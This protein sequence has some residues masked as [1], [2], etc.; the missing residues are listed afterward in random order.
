MMHHIKHH[1]KR[2]HR[3]VV[4]YKHHYLLSSLVVAAGFLTHFALTD[5]TPVGAAGT[6]EL[7]VDMSSEIEIGNGGSGSPLV[8]IKMTSPD[9]DSL[10][11]LNFVMN[12]AGETP[13]NFTKDDIYVV[14]VFVDNGN[15]QW[16]G[17]GVD[18]PVGLAMGISGVGEENALNMCAPKFDEQGSL[19]GCDPS[20][21]ALPSSVA[22]DFNLMFVAFES[23]MKEGDAF[24]LSLTGYTLSS[25]EEV[26]ISGHKTPV[27]V[28]V[29]NE[30]NNGGGGGGLVNMVEINDFQNSFVTFGVGLNGALENG[31]ALSFFFNDVQQ[32]KV[33]FPNNNNL[34]LASHNFE[35][36]SDWDVVHDESQNV[37][38]LVYSDTGGFNGGMITVD[39]LEGW[40]ISNVTEMSL[41]VMVSS[42]PNDVHG[43]VVHSQESSSTICMDCAEEGGGEGSSFSLSATSILDG[44][45]DVAVDSPV[46]AVFTE[47]I[48]ASS[49]DSLKVTLVESGVGINLCD[50]L[51]YPA[52]PDTSAISCAYS[53][54]L[55][56]GTVYEFYV[57]GG[58]DG[59]ASTGVNTLESDVFVTFTT[60]SKEG[61]EKEIGGGELF[62]GYSSPEANAGDVALSD[63]ITVGVLAEIDQT[64]VNS[65]TVLLQKDGTGD[66]LCESYGFLSTSE[67]ECFYSGELSASSLY[68]LTIV[69]GESGVKGLSGETFTSNQEIPFVTGNGLVAPKV[70]GFWAEGSD[71]STTTLVGAM[72]ST[73]MDTNTITTSSLALV[74]FDEGGMPIPVSL[75]T[76]HTFENADTEIYCT[77]DGA[78]KDATDYMFIASTDITD[79]NGVNL[80]MESIGYFTTVGES[81]GEGKK[82]IEEPP[83]IDD[84]SSILSVDPSDGAEGVFVSKRVF[85]VVYDGAI[86]DSSISPLEDGLFA[87]DGQGGSVVG[88]N[89]CTSLGAGVD[90][91][92]LECTIPDEL[93]T[94]TYY[95]FVATVLSNDGS[96]VLDT[97]SE[98]RTNVTDSGVTDPPRVVSVDPRSG[99]RGFPTDGRIAVGFSRDMLNSIGKA[100]SITEHE[101]YTLQEVNVNGQ[102]TGEDVCQDGC[103]F[104]VDSDDGGR[105]VVFI[106][107]NS[108]LL[109]NTE[110]MLT[111]EDTIEDGANISL[112]SAVIVFFETG[113]QTHVE[114]FGELGFSM[115]PASGTE[116]PITQS[117]IE[118]WPS[119]PRL[120]ADSV[121]TTTVVLFADA[122]E[123]GMYDL[124]ETKATD[125]GN[126]LIEYLQNKNVV[127]ANVPGLLPANAQLCAW[128]PP[129]GVT[130]S[131]G[132]SVLTD[133]YSCF[134]TE[135]A[136]YTA[137]S[138]E[139]EG[140]EVDQ[141]NARIW[142]SGPLHA[143]SAV[144]SSSYT[145]YSP[146]NSAIP[147][148]FE[149]VSLEYD[150]SEYRVDIIG[151]TFEPGTDVKV[152]VKSQS[153]PN[154]EATM[155]EDESTNVAVATVESGSYLHDEFDFDTQQDKAAWHENPINLRPEN[156]LA[157]ESGGRWILE[158]QT[159]VALPIGSSIR[160]ILPVGFNVTDDT[161]P[162]PTEY[163]HHNKNIRGYGSTPVT[164]DSYTTNSN[165]RSITFV[166][167]GADIAAADQVRLELVGVNNPNNAGVEYAGRIQ[168]FDENGKNVGSYNAKPFTIQT[169][170]ALTLSGSVYADDNGNNAYDAGEEISGARVFCESRSGVPFHKVAQVDPLGQ[171]QITNVGEN[172]R[173]A[174]GLQPDRSAFGNRYPLHDYEEFM[175]DT[176]D[177]PAI[178]FI[179]SSDLTAVGGVDHTFF[180]NGDSSLESTEIDITCFWDNRS[181]VETVTL[182]AEGFADVTMSLPE[183]V[184]VECATRPHLDSTL[185]GTGRESILVESDYMSE[186]ID[187]Y[188]DPN[189]DPGFDSHT[190]SLTTLDQAIPVRVVGSD[191]SAIANAFVGIVPNQCFDSGSSR[192]SGCEPRAYKT[193]GDGTK[194]IPAVGG[195]FEVAA[196]FKGTS[197]S[198][199]TVVSVDKNGQVWDEFGNEITAANPL[200]LVLSVSSLTISGTYTRGDNAVT[201]EHVSLEQIQ[202]GGTCES[203][204]RI[205]NWRH[206]V[207]DGEGDFTA[208]VSD[209]TWIVEARG[210]CE[211]VVVSGSSRSGI[212]LNFDTADETTISGI[213]PAGAVIS[214]Y[215]SN[216]GGYAVAG[217][218]GV[219]TMGILAGSVSEVSCFSHN[220]GPC[221]REGV[222]SNSDQTINFSTS[223]DTGTLVVNAGGVSDLFVDARN[224]FGGNGTDDNDSGVYTLSL[225]AGSYTVRGANPRLGDIC[226]AQTV[227][228]AKDTTTEVTCSTDSLGALVTPAGQ[229]VDQDGTPI[230]GASVAFINKDTG[231]RF[232]TTSDASTSGINY[233]VLDAP[234]G[235]YHIVARLSGYEPGAV[236]VALSADGKFEIDEDIVLTSAS[237][238]N[239]DVV[240]VQVN[241]NG[242]N[243]YTGIARVVAEKQDGSGGRV[244]KEVNK[245]TGQ[246]T[247]S[248]TNGTWNI[249]ARG[250][251]GASLETTRVVT[252]GSL[253]GGDVTLALTQAIS[254]V[255]GPETDTVSISS[256]KEGV[257]FEAT[258]ISLVEKLIIPENTL[259]LSDSGAGLLE[260]RQDPSI[261]LAD[262]GDG[263]EIVGGTGVDIYV[264]DSS[265]NKKGSSLTG[266]PITLTMNYT[267]EDVTAAGVQEDRLQIFSINANGEL[268]TFSTTVDTENNTLTAQVTHFS[269]FG[270]VG[271]TPSSS[272]GGSGDGGGQV[273][274]AGESSGAG[275]AFLGVNPPTLPTPVSKNVAET[276]VLEVEEESSEV[277]SLGGAEHTLTVLLQN[278]DKVA[279]TIE[280]NPVSLTLAMGE[281][282]IIDTD[283]DEILDLYV[284][285]LTGTVDG[286]H[287]FK[288]R[289]LSDEAERTT[290]F[291]INAGRY[292]V[293]DR[294]VLLSFNVP[295][296]VEVLVSEEA[297]FADAL[298]YTPYTESRMF[299]LSSGNGTKSV[300]VRFRSA[301][302]GIV[303][304]VD[305]IMLTGQR[306]NQAPTE[307]VVE[308]PETVVSCVLK[309]L[310]AYMSGDSAAVYYV[311]NACTK[312]PFK[313]AAIFFSYFSSWDDVTVVDQATL[314]SIP[315]DPQGFLPWGP[316]YTPDQGSLLQVSEDTKVY[317]FL[318]G[319]LHEI[320]NVASAAYQFGPSWQ[321]LVQIVDSQL[322]SLFDISSNSIGSDARPDGFVFK[323][324]GSNKVYELETVENVQVKRWIVDEATFRSR[325]YKWRHIMTL[326]DSEVYPDGASLA[327]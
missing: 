289:N 252:G 125:V 292:E 35:V 186:R 162:V 65:N 121:N 276:I 309:T 72:F 253:I 122:N 316:R 305:T 182:D 154:Q 236:D 75:C 120:D 267:D 93:D 163:S 137:E 184:H 235:E 145:F 96:T 114:A 200:E 33:V 197:P 313:T 223:I 89:L 157:G 286:R 297:D 83:Q 216:G 283:G 141:H 18:M 319:T 322:K 260:V 151:L 74:E 320:E 178:D 273:G 101:N 136:V 113:S 203:A 207:T 100:G 76:G 99:S 79:I 174:C 208:Y 57:Q 214:A 201:Y 25:G 327:E 132:T 140:M 234:P 190:F 124:G 59:I 91:S 168:T 123:N 11:K 58:P 34:K 176:G 205:G 56:E 6:E 317:W 279:I 299:T 52:I 148:M 269:G 185:V 42:D 29:D 211:V 213:A 169:A 193:L 194:S 278:E 87:L 20:P 53:G 31:Q 221:G 98:F 23:G 13:E 206:T 227:T 19:T 156:T 233:S 240:T 133:W 291:T 165:A 127:R 183:D 64:T 304:V 246:V 4:K 285:Y 159:E 16:D 28:A 149:N 179:L 5:R 210:S 287:T 45:G 264:T 166:T 204:Q 77:Y 172:V 9:G 243:A 152:V 258:D 222:N 86:D 63:T 55:K 321:T 284:E 138:P 155:M 301:E 188:V 129:G 118:I 270:V 106:K 192:L 67:F 318:R 298:V 26:A 195:M 237:G 241:D 280:S 312:R 160:A 94:N 126:I 1:A 215:G 254:G 41:M 119:V 266:E 199:T 261:V 112:A 255:S 38:Q 85:A 39:T 81:A 324:A 116:V 217:S 24:T 62:L 153:D 37:Y 50:S 135:N 323:Y 146:V 248:L 142:F 177:V 43:S 104:V 110:Y 296:A 189:P 109:P 306:F 14:A 60:I 128:I 143:E 268:E 2:A 7:V 88:E 307:D 8:G 111:V 315:D 277:F 161:V 225:A 263:Q 257:I 36:G 44:Q 21:F 310:R 325:G 232:L 231:Q 108:A 281:S 115:V 15:G 17:L 70:L 275:Y 300:Y 229:V 78:L 219:Y 326:P 73:S 103:E 46:V 224:S 259:D 84:A 66:N 175:V 282:E 173:V 250:E 271:G 12:G 239:G 274:G 51:E 256:I 242:G 164:I 95:R 244:I 245:A 181:L 198:E 230:S 47:Q 308:E 303:D 191:E 105:D 139:V 294:D 49:V 251:L 228:I 220:F 293:D 302:G 187:F 68:V 158:F 209:G 48:D 170:G 295:A 10:T 32:N 171:W 61:G 272:G 196:F 71:I 92:S 107:P 40:P 144:A 82:E 238:A 212:S 288:L 54:T 102:P 22:V 150:P 247:L 97:M 290:A 147:L 265:G 226:G 69:S 90:G 130:D 27:I 167:A 218:D 30:E 262:A 314:E 80:D 3:H 117:A 131:L 202:S 311:T 134:R 249:W 180:V